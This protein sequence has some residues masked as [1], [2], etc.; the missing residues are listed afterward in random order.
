MKLGVLWMIPTADKCSPGLTPMGY[1]VLVALDVLEE[2]T[3][4]GIIIPDKHRERQDGASERGRIVAASEMAF[5]GGDW[6]G[7][8]VPTVGNV[9]LFQRYAGTEFEGEDGFKYRIIAD[10]DLKGVFD[11]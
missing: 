3:A 1:N 8:N 2:K 7:V 5:K 10:A 6:D 11:G 9:V 4:G